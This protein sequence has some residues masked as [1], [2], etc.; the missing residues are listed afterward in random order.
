MVVPI[1]RNPAGRSRSPLRQGAF[2][3]AQV[4]I[5]AARDGLLTSL[6]NSATPIGGTVNH[7]MVKTRLARPAAMRCI[8]LRSP[9]SRAASKGSSVPAANT[10]L[11][12]TQA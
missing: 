11:L 5:G 10:L 4:R 1:A 2:G 9:S 6:D 3:W 8:C 12:S 7:G